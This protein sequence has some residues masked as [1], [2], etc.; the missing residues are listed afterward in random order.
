MGK[1]MRKIWILGSVLCVCLM[2]GGCSGGKEISQTAQPE[3]EAVEETTVTGPDFFDLDAYEMVLADWLAKQPQEKEAAG[4][5]LIYLD[6]DEIPELA[7]IEGWAHAS[8]VNIYTYEEGAAVFVGKYGQYGAMGYRQK[9]GIVFDDYDQGGNTFSQVY[10]IDKCNAALLT[11]YSVYYQFME[12]E[13]P[14][15]I[16]TVDGQEVSQKQYQEVSERWGT[17]GMRVIDYGMC[18]PITEVNIRQSLEDQLEA[19]IL[20]QK[21]ILQ[22]RVLAESG[23][24]ENAVLMMDYDDYDRDGK[25]EAFMFCGK[26]IEDQFYN[27]EL[28]FVGEKQCTLLREGTYRMVDGKMSLGLNQKYLYLYRDSNLTANISELWTVI[29]GEPVES[30]LS[31]RGQI[32]YR[33]GNNFEI[34]MDGYDHYY[35]PEADLWSGHTYKPYFYHY[36]WG[37]GKLEQYVKKPL[38]DEEL[39]ELCGFDLAA[40]VRAESYEITEIVQWG[41]RIVTVNYTIPFDENATIPQIVYE[42]IIWDCSTNDYWRKEE[43]GVTSWRNAGVGGSF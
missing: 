14:E 43:R 10:Q 18:I 12:T 15:I 3:L 35:E 30:E 33:C 22:Q 23:F 31:G 1:A 39:A 6:K 17:A 34:W 37:T 41:D 42:N 19:L 27:G 26:C 29:D 9:E 38:S 21:E 40:Q 28:W 8:G 16:Y 25:C 24:T 7:I 2:F 36:N 4:F 5:A 32:V 11:S 13:D 20:T